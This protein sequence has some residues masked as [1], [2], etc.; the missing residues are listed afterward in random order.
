MTYQKKKRKKYSRLERLIC[1]IIIMVN[2]ILCIDFVRF[3]ECY[4]TTWKYKLK[5][6]IASGNKQSIEYYEKNY[7]AHGKSLY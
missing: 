7:I 6:E 3:P 5:N 4:L 2:L 1:F